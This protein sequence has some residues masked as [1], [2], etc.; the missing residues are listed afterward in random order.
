[1]GFNIYYLWLSNRAFNSLFVWYA[2]F[3]VPTI[4]YFL[5]C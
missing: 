3:I 5:T 2:P 4:R 1:M